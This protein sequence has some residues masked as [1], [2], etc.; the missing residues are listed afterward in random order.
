MHAETFD[1]KKRVVWLEV[2]VFGPAGRG[3]CRFILDT[4]SPVTVISTSVIDSLGYSARMGT[5]R[6]QLIGIEGAQEGYRLRIEQ[7]QT[8]GLD[9]QD[10][11]VFCHD[12]DERLGVDGL[13]GMDLLEGHVLTLDC[14]QG[15]VTLG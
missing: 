10:R 14:V 2:Q 13:I 6:S 3:A 4:G 7:L 1:P 15:T 9:V 11:E 12:F 5:T 8:L